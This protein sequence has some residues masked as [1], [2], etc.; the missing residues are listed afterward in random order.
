MHDRDYANLSRR[1]D[2]DDGIGESRQEN[3]ADRQLG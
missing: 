2:K 1:L 3:A